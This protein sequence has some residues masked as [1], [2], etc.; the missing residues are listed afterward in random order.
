MR[1]GGGF[2]HRFGLDSGVLIKDNHIAAAGSIAAR[3]SAPRQL[4]PHTVKIEVE[5]ETL[6]QVEEALDAG[7]TVILLDNMSVDEDA[8]G[9]A[10]RRAG[11]AARSF[12]RMSRSRGARRSPRPGS[13]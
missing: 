11:G 5:C 1:V 4:A 13:I 10:D 7:A 12:G 9:A 3:S 8:P 2:N 6:E